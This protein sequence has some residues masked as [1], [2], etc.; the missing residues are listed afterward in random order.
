MQQASALLQAGDFARAQ[1]MLEQVL[2]TEPR[3]VE[4]HRLLAGALQ[5]LGDDPGAERA[6]RTAVAIDPGWAPAQ[7]SLGELL[8]HLGRTAEAET[9]LRAALAAGRNH[10][11]AAAI[12]AR[13]LNAD[14]RPQEALDVCAPFAQSM[15]PDLDLLTQQ[16]A[17]LSALGRHE[18]AISLY[19]RIVEA[20][21]GNA[22]A[23]YNLAAALEAAGSHRDAE[24]AARRAIGRG[25]DMP[26]AHAVHAR[27]LIGLNRFDEAESALLRAIGQRETFADAQR[28]LAQL[29]WMRSGDVAAACE[30]LDAALR[31]HPDDLALLAIKAR[32][33]DG[34]GDARAA[35]ACMAERVQGPTGNLDALLTASQIALKFDSARARA[36]AERALSIAPD[37][38]SVRL[39]F[40]DTLLATGDADQAARIATELLLD[41]PDD[42][43]LLA[44][45]TTAWRLLGDP[46]YA[47]HC[48]YARM[49]RAWVLDTPRGWSDLPAYLRDLAASLHA[50][51]TLHTHPLHQS[52]RNGSQTTQKN[53]LETDDPVLRAFPE[54]IDGP[55]HRH[56]G[57]LGH[58]GDPLRR[59]NSGGYRI[60]GIWSVR[61]RGQGYHVNHVHPEGW[62]SSACYIELPRAMAMGGGAG[63]DGT[64]ES[65]VAA[66]HEKAGWLKFGEPGI[67]TNPML[68]PESFIRPEPGLLAL[69]P[70]YFWHGTVPFEGDDTRLTIAFDLVPAAHR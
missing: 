9:P 51:H 23:E 15:P 7:T 50:L 52:L 11:R 68:A 41:K 25:A 53:L 33:L 65:P 47:G 17:A 27:G 12:L 22:I 13:L 31:A 2:R 59:R 1:A 29:I 34:A 30:H 69:F 10:L 61:L 66:D 49:A 40:A 16:A 32:L 57:M 19:R 54:A 20:V 8:V 64:G 3:F 43:R 26:E 18:E 24:S 45:L 38:P 62:L 60:H 39:L 42:Q 21:P 70:S 58:G 37:Q 46:R 14:A 35:Y 56:I 28:N 4:A 44:E 55:I 6:L 63:A 67:P 48:D 5:A 36:H